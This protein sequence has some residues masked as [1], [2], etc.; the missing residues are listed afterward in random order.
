[1]RERT[2]HQ[3]SG[4]SL[5]NI[6]GDFPPVEHG[7]YIHKKV[8]FPEGRSSYRSKATLGGASTLSKA[9]SHVTAMVV[10]PTPP[11]S[12]KVMKVPLFFL[13]AEGLGP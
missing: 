8:Y 7:L 10:V 9:C 13:S 12:K 4:S 1:M 2:P 6:S 5:E 11:C 3:I